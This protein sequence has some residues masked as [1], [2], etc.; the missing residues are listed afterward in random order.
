M[1]P[2]LRALTALKAMAAWEMGEAALSLSSALQSH[3]QVQARATAIDRQAEAIALAHARAAQPGQRLELAS[4][5]LLSRQASASQ[6]LQRQVNGELHQADEL[7]QQQR[8]ELAQHRARDEALQKVVRQERQ[9]EE[10]E[11][12]KVELAN[13]DD[14]YLARRWVMEAWA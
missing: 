3:E 1:T 13:L 14:L 5:G 11:R 12:A 8:T 7:V 9:R 10:A 6:E 2:T 4:M